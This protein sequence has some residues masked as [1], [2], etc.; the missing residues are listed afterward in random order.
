M[1]T[2]F[3]LLSFACLG[4]LTSCGSD[5]GSEAEASSDASDETMT[6]R[7]APAA[8]AGNGEVVNFRELKKLLPENLAGLKR[9]DYNGQTTGAMGFNI[10]VAEATYEDGDSRLEVVITDTGGLV[11][12]AT[13]LA[14]WANM[15]ID[16]ESDTGYQRTTTIGGYKAFESYDRADNSG[17]L[18]LFIGE[19]FVVVIEGRNID[20]S[21]F[22][23]LIEE[24]DL[25]ELET[26]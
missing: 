4:L 26:L 24:I 25:R 10:S 9:V 7:E 22:R 13:S 19:R 6:D 17:E 11:A 1:K 15:E 18:S 5:S 21:A 2:F 3:M 16:R 14:A 23:D 12:A 20:E 8:S